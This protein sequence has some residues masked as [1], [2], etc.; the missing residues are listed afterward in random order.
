MKHHHKRHQHHGSHH[1]DGGEVPSHVTDGEGSADYKHGGHIPK[2]LRHRHHKAKGGGV[3]DEDGG[4]HSA[5]DAVPDLVSGN[6]VVVK[7]AKETKSIGEV[8]GIYAKKRFD[9][10]SRTGGYDHGGHSLVKGGDH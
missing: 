5:T 1:K 4:K 2:H 9:R 10:K 7:A 6:K 3:H 8:P